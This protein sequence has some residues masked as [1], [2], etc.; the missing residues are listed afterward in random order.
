LLERLAYNRA[1]LRGFR[2]RNRG[3]TM[4]LEPFREAGIQVAAGAGTARGAAGPKMG[5]SGDG[6]PLSPPW[7][8]RFDCHPSPFAVFV[9]FCTEPDCQCTDGT[10]RLV[11]AVAPDQGGRVGL[12]LEVLV[13]LGDG[14]M[15]DD[16]PADD[17]SHPVAQ[18]LLAELPADLVEE[19]RLAQA[20]A[21]DRARQARSFR[22]PLA[23]LLDGRRASWSAV[24]DEHG[25]VLDGGQA[26]HWRVEHEGVTYLVE[27]EYC[28][29]PKCDCRNATLVFLQTDTETER[30]EEA[31]QIVVG[32][33]GQ[34]EQLNAYTCTP[35]EARALHA[36]WVAQMDEPLPKTLADAYAELKLVGERLVVEGTRPH[37]SPEKVGRN[38]PCPCGSGKKYKKCCLDRDKGRPG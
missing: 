1:A 12:D 25:S 28:L 9:S 3:R 27:D 26:Y 21:R 34:I 5:D 24:F 19:L 22:M 23:D 6:V 16:E 29:N 37:R 18:E 17:R 36:S 4:R 8:A 7:A 14:P 10:F 31:C 20:L 32:F 30:I 15:A 35:A 13:Q 11:E 38:D 2:G 33:D